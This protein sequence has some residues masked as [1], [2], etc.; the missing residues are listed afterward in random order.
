MHDEYILYDVL[1]QFFFNQVAILYCENHTR[2]SLYVCDSLEKMTQEYYSTAKIWPRSVVLDP[3]STTT[4]DGMVD[5]CR[6]WY[7]V[8]SDTNN[9]Q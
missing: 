3:Q 2:K 7:T 1:L 4:P 9:Q 6:V 5:I 8:V